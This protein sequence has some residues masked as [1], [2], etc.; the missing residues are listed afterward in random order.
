[1]CGS[2]VVLSKKLWKIIRLQWGSLRFYKFYRLYDRHICLH[3]IGFFAKFLQTWTLYEQKRLQ[4][5]YNWISDLQLIVNGV[6]LMNGEDAVKLV[7]REFKQERGKWYSGRNSGGS[8]VQDI[9]P[10]Q[11]LVTLKNVQVNRYVVIAT[12]IIK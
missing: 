3:D 9:L 11:D 6:N 5:F 1:M 4:S 10:N 7:V 8:Y 2:E 12:I